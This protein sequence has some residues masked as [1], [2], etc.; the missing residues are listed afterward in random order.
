MT[1]LAFEN[2]TPTEAGQSTVTPLQFERSEVSLFRNLA[3]LAQKAG[4]PQPSLLKLAFKELADNALD[5][6]AH[7]TFEHTDVLTW[8]KDD[9][10]G[11]DG[12]DEEIAYLFSIG[13]PLRSSKLIRLPT[14]GALGNG[15]RVVVGL[16]LCTGGRLVVRT[17]G[18]ELELEPRDNGETIV[19][20]TLTWDGAGTQVGVSFGRVESDM[21][22]WAQ[23]AADRA[24]A[25][26]YKGA[27]SPY[28]YDSDS[29]FELCTAAAENVS[30]RALVER[31]DG[32]S[33]GKA[34]QIAAPFLNRRVRDLSR[35]E[36]E[37]L[38]VAAREHAREVTPKRLGVLG[39]QPHLPG[40]G[41]ALGVIEIGGR[42][43]GKCKATLPVVV[44]AW[45]KGRPPQS[46]VVLLVNRTVAAAA[47]SLYDYDK[48][49]QVSGCHY[50]GESL[51]SGG[52]DYQIEINIQ[53]PHIPITSDGK[54]PD[55]APFKAL[56]DE[57]IR[58]AVNRAKKAAGILR[59]APE[60]RRTFKDSVLDHIAAAIALASGDGK[61][62]FNL[63]NLYYQVRPFVLREVGELAYETFTSII[64][65]Y[66]N[67]NGPIEGMYRNERGVLIHPHTGE[68][69]GLGTLTVE[70]YERPPW[71]FNKV[72]YVEKEGFFETLRA[73]K[74]PERHDC[75]LMT[76][77]GFASRAARDLIDALGE[78]DEPIE[79]FCIH[80]ADA[81]G[82]MI[83]QSLCEATRARPERTIEIVN[84]G[85]ERA[86]AEAMK[87]ECE[88]LPSAK[89]YKPTAAYVSSADH[90]WY[91]SNRYELNAMTAPQLIAWLD[92]K[93][94]EH[95]AGK[96]VPPENVMREELGARLEARVRE[97]ET[98]RILREAG[99]DAIV[100]ARVEALA[101]DVAAAGSTLDDDVRDALDDEPTDSWRSVV[102]NLAD[103]IAGDA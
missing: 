40:Y 16:V 34:G 4:V 68:E 95:A 20:S 64:T 31:L 81:Y 36:A 24:G 83:Y 7:V 102:E 72:L 74:W 60:Y 86:E 79:I 5:A 26:S 10:P 17:R 90:G 53:T 69:I 99:L 57:A 13:R 76:S 11:I 80:D 88:R 21:L 14:R 30:P 84:L 8:V 66:E 73:D 96:V 94:E 58:A 52:N 48:H 43:S 49:V 98:E 70:K 97:I 82:T 39:E 67:D 103:E 19:K 44:E 78:T 51:P 92:R 45:A 1:A 65:D 93:M 28:W 6:G 37:A 12:T 100:A 42:T 15:I 63:R 89:K 38:L 62:R 3:T 101:D 56:L 87:L 54:S 47:M 2:S 22:D 41:K 91:Q 59:A 23:L 75:A 35:R 61:Y 55:L 32:C 50:S 29:F 18:R 9:G 85:L 33:G 27:S 46:G 25:E 71:T 77:Q